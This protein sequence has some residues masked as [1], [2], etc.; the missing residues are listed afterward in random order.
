MSDA[1]ALAAARAAVAAKGAEREQMRAHWGYHREPE[2]VLADEVD[3][4][5]AVVWDQTKLR[6]SLAGA[7]LARDEAQ[8]ERNRLRAVARDVW[9]ALWHADPAEVELLGAEHEAMLPDVVRSALLAAAKH[10]N[11]LSVERDRLR[12]VVDALRRHR[13]A[14]AQLMALV[15]GDED[16]QREADSRAAGYW[17]EVIESL[18][19][20]DGSAEATD[21]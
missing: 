15:D 7:R 8:E 4:L 18:A 20:L 2:E 13:V 12:A 11:E 17:Q 3:R 9:A 14:D 1:N 10:N 16:Q 5:E 6:A 19:A 21:A